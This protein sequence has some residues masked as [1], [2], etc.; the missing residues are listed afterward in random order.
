MF[1]LYILYSESADK[2]YIGH[3]SDPARRLEEHNNVIKNSYTFRY[4]PWI[5]K[6]C[7]P[8]SESRRDARIIENYLKKLKSRIIIKKLINNPEE[9]EVLIRKVRAVPTCRD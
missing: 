6:S 3:T 2:Y 1:Y 8:V 7:F 5:L 9:F 4:R